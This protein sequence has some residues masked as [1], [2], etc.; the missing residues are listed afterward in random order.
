M[1][2]NLLIVALMGMVLVATGQRQYA[3][4]SVLS[5][6]QWVKIRTTKKAIYKLTGE[7]LVKAG[8]PASPNSNNIHVFGN[9]GAVLPED[10]RTAV[11]DDL[12]ENAIWVEDGGDGTFDAND[13]LLFYV[14]GPEVW[15]FDSSKNDFTFL[16]HP[17]SESSFYFITVNSTPGKR[18]RQQSPPAGLGTPVTEYDELV[19]HELDSVNLLKSGKEW[20]GEEFNAQLGKNSR[21][22][23]PSVYGYNPRKTNPG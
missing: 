22:F 4:G 3:S 8:F 7:M 5:V 15:R 2:I 20:Y 14:E 1:K 6:G 10:N 12:A 23:Q 9:G 21:T 18:I 19:H 16:H 13:W 11:I 17:Y